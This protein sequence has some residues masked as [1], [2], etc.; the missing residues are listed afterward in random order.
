MENH[1]EELES[2]EDFEDL[3]EEVQAGVNSMVADVNK[4]VQALQTSKAAHEEERK[5]LTLNIWQK[6]LLMRFTTLQKG[7]RLC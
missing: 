2:M 7:E 1:H 4:E 3:Q 6:S 5:D